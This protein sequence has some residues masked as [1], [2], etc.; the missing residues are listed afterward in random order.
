MATKIKWHRYGTKLR[1]CHPLYTYRLHPF[2]IYR[3][4]SEETCVTYFPYAVDTG[5]FDVRTPAARTTSFIFLLWIFF[6]ASHRIGWR[7][8]V[9][10]RRSLTGELSLSCARPAADG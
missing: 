7:G 8:T 1:H 3:R 2:V 6:V 5:L 9:V 4:P 10:E